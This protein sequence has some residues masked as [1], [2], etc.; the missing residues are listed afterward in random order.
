MFLFKFIFVFQKRNSLIN[1]T[2][3]KCRILIMLLDKS[4][5]D[6]CGTSIW[7]PRQ[8]VCFWFCLHPRISTPFKIAIDCLWST[9]SVEEYFTSCGKETPFY[10]EIFLFRKW[11]FLVHYWIQFYRETRSQRAIIMQLTLINSTKK[12]RIR[13]KLRLFTLTPMS[14][15]VP[16]EYIAGFMCASILM[17]NHGKHENTKYGLSPL[18]TENVILKYKLRFQ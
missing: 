6:V 11:D 10:N 4:D 12:L 9:W 8:I 17:G 1:I 5:G 16:G 14:I 18:H 3:M 13:R 2:R 15:V 7:Q